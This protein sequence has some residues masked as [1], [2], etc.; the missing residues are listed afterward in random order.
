MKDTLAFSG[1]IHTLEEQAVASKGWAK[2]QASYVK[3]KTKVFAEAASTNIYAI[4]MWAYEQP[5]CKAY[6]GDAPWLLRKQISMAVE[7][8][9]SANEKEIMDFLAAKP[10]VPHDF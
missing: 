4:V 5:E 7:A 10:S 8:Y 2:M 3:I 6:Y 9:M 1:K